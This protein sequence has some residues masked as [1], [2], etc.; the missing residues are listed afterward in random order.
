MG[1]ASAADEALSTLRTKV[2]V[3]DSQRSNHH[4]KSG[5]GGKAFQSAHDPSGWDR[6]ARYQR[7]FNTARNKMGMTGMDDS[8]EGWSPAPKDAE[9]AASSPD[10]RIG[11]NGGLH[12]RNS[13]T[14]GS[15]GGG[16]AGAVMLA[17]GAGGAYTIAELRTPVALKEHLK[18][19]KGT[20]DS[21]INLAADADGWELAVNDDDAAAIVAQFDQ[22]RYMLGGVPAAA[23]G[24]RVTLTP[25]DRA[26]RAW[27]NQNPSPYAGGAGGSVDSSAVPSPT[28]DGAAAACAPSAEAGPVAVPTRRF[29]ENGMAGGCGV[30]GSGSFPGVRRSASASTSPSGYPNAPPSP[31]LLY[32][33]APARPF[34]PRISASGAGA[35]AAAGGALGLAARDNSPVPV[36]SPTRAIKL[37]SGGAAALS[38]A[39]AG[40]T[41]S[42]SAGGG[43]SGADGGPLPTGGPPSAAAAPATPVSDAVLAGLRAVAAEA[44]QELNREAETMRTV[45][46]IRNRMRAEQTAAGKPRQFCLPGDPWKKF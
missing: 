3:A 6:K 28:M 32:T 24:P 30:V 41:G 42:G 9:A 35:P 37:P 31:S 22:K 21:T 46:A 7:A 20:R 27:T 10:R 33:P 15:T 39:A 40:G 45:A 5:A 34:A 23:S 26:L 8:V 44:E 13:L 1:H 14:H 4:A 18:R 11:G 43:G 16:A 25:A 2:A 12:R 17:P 29:S 38:A 36:P 19:G